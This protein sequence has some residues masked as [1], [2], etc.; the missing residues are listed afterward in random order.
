MF[1]LE[2]KTGLVVGTANEESLAAACARAFAAQG[3]RLALTYQ[4][5]RTLPYMRPVADSVSADI[6]MPLDVTD[7]VQE[8]ALFA[9][10]KQRWGTLDFLLHAVAFA[11]KADLQGRVTDCSAQGFLTAAD[12]SCHSF[13]RLVKAAEPLMSEGGCA[14]TLS[15]IGAARAVKNYNLM[16]P[17]KAA[18]ES[19]VKYMAAELGPSGIRVNALSTGPVRT[20]A[21]SGLKDFDELIKKS[22]EKAPLHHVTDPRRIGATAAFLVS[23]EAGDITGQVVYV[24]GGYSVA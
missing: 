8:Q 4:N 17:V 9:E 11:P 12:I 21:A 15:Y 24:D 7:P 16:G 5:A 23:E 1:S 6:V 20:R 14:L 18:L 19:A 13:I 2:G 3:A 22:A 10:I